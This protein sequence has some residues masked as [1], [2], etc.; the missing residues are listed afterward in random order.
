M[1]RGNVI[2]LINCSTITNFVLKYNYIHV[3]QSLTGN[4]GLFICRIAPSDAKSISLRRS[5]DPHS[6]VTYSSSKKS[7]PNAT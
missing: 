4:T 3:T 2:K 6:L 1:K 7:I 5:C